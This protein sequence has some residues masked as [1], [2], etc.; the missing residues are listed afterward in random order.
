M[1]TLEQYWHSGGGKKGAPN[2]HLL[3]LR[4]RPNKSPAPR[5]LQQRQLQRPLIQQLDL[6][7]LSKFVWFDSCIFHPALGRYW[8]NSGDC[9]NV[10][11]EELQC[12]SRFLLSYWRQNSF[13]WSVNHWLITT[14]GEEQ[15]I[16]KIS[17]EDSGEHRC[18]RQSTTLLWYGSK[19]LT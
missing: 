11:D 14:K 12:I 15:K 3:M 5:P 8:I 19:L 9:S 2:K 7:P 10:N 4:R 18:S 16:R 17:L 1:L 6:G 13:L